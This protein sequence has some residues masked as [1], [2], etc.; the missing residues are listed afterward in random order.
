MDLLALLFHFF[1]NQKNR[2]FIKT[3]NDFSLYAAVLKRQINTTLSSESEDKSI[4]KNMH[5]A[6]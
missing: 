6:F 2:L 5:L 4:A 3:E 1:L